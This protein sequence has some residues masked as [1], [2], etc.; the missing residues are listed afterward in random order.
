MI[1]DLE[2]EFLSY[3]RTRGFR[4]YESFPLVID[5]P[6]I[7]FTNATVTPF[8]PMFTGARERENFALVQKCLRL[9]GSSG[10]LETPR[11]NPNHTSLFTM[12]GSGLFDIEQESAVA[13]FVDVLVKLGLSRDRLVFTALSHLGF[14]Q[15]LERAGIGEHQIRL[16]VDAKDLQHEW[17]FGEGDLHGCGVVARYI[18]DECL[19]RTYD[20]VV[21]ELSCYLQ[22][23]RL[24]HIDGISRG[25]AVERNEFSAY[26]MGIGLGRVEAALKG[27]CEGSLRSWRLCANRLQMS[28]PNLSSG[29]AH[30]MA[31]L[32]RVVEELVS[33]GLL[34][35]KKKHAFVLRKVMRLLIEEIWLQSGAL[36]DTSAILASQN[37]VPACRDLLYSTFSQEED[38]LRKILSTVKEKQRKHAEMSAEQ[39]RATFGIR[40]GLLE[41]EE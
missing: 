18:P 33:E 16:F 24:V 6:T 3:H 38:A 17:S 40:F 25:A 37:A 12:L 10:N 2:Q 13:Y 32:F 1:R 21:Q 23:G 39:L 35:G 11:T 15:A 4:I 41:L 34:P 9:G 20:D 5:D 36:V 22:I 14:G 19:G 8:K 26:D 31:N 30:Y 28:M 27:N 29:D 7:L